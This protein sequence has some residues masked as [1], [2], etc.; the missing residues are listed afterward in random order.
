MNANTQKIVE[1]YDGTKTSLEVARLLNLN[2][3]YVR[4]VAQKLGLV[5]LPP[6]ARTSAL[7]HQYVSGRRIDPDGYV[8]V[9]A[10]VDHPYARQRS[11]RKQGKLIF[12]HRLNLE[13]KLGRYLLPTEVVDHIDGLT[14]H[15]DPTNLRLFSCNGEHLYETTTGIPKNFS[16]K[17]L[18]MIRTPFDQRKDLTQ[19][20]TYRLRRVRGDVRL[21]QILHAALQLGIDSP[22][23]LGTTYWLNKAGILEPSRPNLKLALDQLKQRWEADL[24]Q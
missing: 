4:K 3:R 12:E 22:Y 24:Y 21:R 11:G 7:N 9:T 20:D 15:N 2:P 6:G 5:R 8:L 13:K 17:G 16:S 14:L 10:P 1:L 23:L 18:K 19:V